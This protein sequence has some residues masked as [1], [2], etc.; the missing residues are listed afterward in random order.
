MCSVILFETALTVSPITN[1]SRGR[2][3]LVHSTLADRGKLHVKSQSKR[4]QLLPIYFK[5]YTWTQNVLGNQLWVIQMRMMKMCLPQEKSE[6][7]WCAVLSNDKPPH[8][9]PQGVRRCILEPSSNRL[10]EQYGVGH[11]AQT[12][13]HMLL[14][15][16][17]LPDLIPHTLSID[18]KTLTS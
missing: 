16:E 17:R 8:H 11:L 15:R 5:I 10:A 18:C 13:V 2:H 6:T 14:H 4:H 9:R 3:T 7:H 12:T 1:V